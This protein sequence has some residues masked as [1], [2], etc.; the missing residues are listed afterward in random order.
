MKPLFYKSGVMYA[1]ESW[2]A[3]Q[4][5]ETFTDNF[6]ELE[7]GKYIFLTEEQEEFYHNHLDFDVYHLYYM[8]PLNEEE[9][10]LEDIKENETIENNRGRLYRDMADPLYM[11]YVK[12]VALGNTDKATEYYNRWLEVVNQIKEQNPYNIVI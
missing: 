8:L 4:D 7:N 5:P 1:D 12:N 2:I 3:E 9:Q 10:R 6:E 11:G